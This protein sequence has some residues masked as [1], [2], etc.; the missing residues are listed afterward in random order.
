MRRTSFLENNR[1]DPTSGCWNWTA[2]RVSCRGIKTYGQ[3]T[4]LGKKELVHRISAHIYLGYDLKSPLR[5]LHKCDNRACFNPK[6]LYIG[7][8][9]EN[10]RDM[11]ARGRNHHKSKPKLAICARGHARIPE[12]LRGRRC[13]LCDTVY[14]HEK[15]IH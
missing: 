15:A 4:Y 5:V 11:Y 8:Q 12:N 6:H 1:Y 13:K 14:N 9:L 7:T 3:S 10:V 2:S